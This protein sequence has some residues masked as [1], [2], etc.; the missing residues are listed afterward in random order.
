MSGST[1]SG[2]GVPVGS[3]G[4]R[5]SEGRRRDMERLGVVGAGFMGT[6]IAESAAAAGFEVA[7]YEPIE[8]QIARSKERIVTSLGRAVEGGKRT[9][10]EADALLERVTWSPELDAVARSELVIE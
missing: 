7:L 4:R 6:G 8:P 10:E 3:P 9:H 5:A 1:T 2:P